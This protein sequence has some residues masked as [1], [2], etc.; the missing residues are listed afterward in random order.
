LHLAAANLVHGGCPAYQP[1]ATSNF[2]GTQEGAGRPN[3]WP[4]VMGT[5]IF[6][7]MLL[8][9]LFSVSRAQ[10]LTPGPAVSYEGR[11]VSSVEIAGRPDLDLRLLQSLIAQPVN[12]PY[13]QEKVDETVATLKSVG[14]FQDVELQVAPEAAGLRLLFVLQPALYFGVF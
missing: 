10:E 8:L 14:Q 7:W 3:T 9:A 6:I 1:S 4:H 12:A 5:S 13:S 2:P 11:S